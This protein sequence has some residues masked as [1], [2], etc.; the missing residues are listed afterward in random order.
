MA[1]SVIPITFSQMASNSDPRSF[2]IVSSMP[3]EW[4]NAKAELLEYEYA[5][6]MLFANCSRILH[7]LSVRLLDFFYRDVFRTSPLIVFEVALGEVL[8]P[9][10]PCE[11][12][13]QGQAVRTPGTALLHRRSSPWFHF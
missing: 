5:G 13:V 8:D 4:K 7:F 11:E 6:L 12:L 1:A 3:I 2:R 10:S 9:R